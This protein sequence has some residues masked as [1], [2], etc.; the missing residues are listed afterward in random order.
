MS[1]SLKAMFE[2]LPAE[3]RSR[4]EARA[5]E[6][7]AEEKT[8]AE[9]R[10]AQKLTQAKMA[11]KLGIK[12]ESVSNIENRADLLLSTLRNYVR[13]AGGELSLRVSFPDSPAIELMTVQGVQRKKIVKNRRHTSATSRIKRAAS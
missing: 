4:I 2:K 7:V 9:L 13:A 12:Q 3:R 8:L 6:L 10:K 5:Q 1:V 11:R